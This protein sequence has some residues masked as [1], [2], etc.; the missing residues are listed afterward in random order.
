M[1]LAPFSEQTLI[2]VWTLPG[3]G[4]LHAVHDWLV[5]GEQS[6]AAES[7]DQGLTWTPI[8]L[9]IGGDLHAIARVDQRL[10][11]VGDELVL[12]RESDGTWLEPPPPPEGWGQLRDVHHDPVVDRTWA[13]GLGGRIWR[14]A[15]PRES[16]LAEDSGTTAD[17]FAIARFAAGSEQL[18]AA[19]ADGALQVRERTSEA[20]PWRTEA[21]GVEVD[22]LDAH[23]G[24]LL[25]A[26]GV[27]LEHAGDGFEI[28]ETVAGAR[29][30]A[31]DA[32]LV[33]DAGLVARKRFE[34]CY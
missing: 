3:A 21:S 30:L 11:V 27:L 16:W 8:E 15:D 31:G 7:L 13:V 28:V 23:Q 29:K 19:G 17:L 25:T 20:S 34:A 18:M 33:G 32:Y 6:F 12:V 24:K 9:G 2:E 26:E 22:I 14:S 10:V 5:V 4:E 1:G